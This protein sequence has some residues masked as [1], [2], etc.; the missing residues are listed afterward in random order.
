LSKGTR[1]CHRGTVPMLLYSEFARPDYA[2]ANIRNFVPSSALDEWNFCETSD[3]LSWHWDAT[4]VS[5]FRNLFTHFRCAPWYEALKCP[6]P[7]GGRGYRC[8]SLSASPSCTPDPLLWDVAPISASSIN[9]LYILLQLDVH[10][11]LLGQLTPRTIV[12]LRK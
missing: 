3:C 1:L 8:S 7:L 11:D 10:W 9:E 12:Y 2:R 6:W 4:D 5:F